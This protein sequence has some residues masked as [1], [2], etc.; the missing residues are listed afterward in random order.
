MNEYMKGYEKTEMPVLASEVS[1]PRDIVSYTDE[2][3]KE[4]LSELHKDIEKIL[5]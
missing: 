4:I 5:Y 3:K 1:F 2:E